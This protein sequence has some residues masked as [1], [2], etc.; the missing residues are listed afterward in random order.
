MINNLSI[1]CLLAFYKLALGSSTLFPLLAS[2][3]LRLTRNIGAS[4]RNKIPRLA[5]KTWIRG[6]R[7][8]HFF[9]KLHSVRTWPKTR[10][11]LCQ[12]WFAWSVVDFPH[13]N[14][15]RVPYHENPATGVKRAPDLILCSFLS[16]F[17][18][19]NWKGFWGSNFGSFSQKLRSLI[20]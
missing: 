1:F 7:Y 12:L 3:Q 9:Y 2:L 17:S 8:F 4:G 6:R 14:S 20:N 15:H 19:G 11:S 16:L 13:Q 5:S 10:R 18:F